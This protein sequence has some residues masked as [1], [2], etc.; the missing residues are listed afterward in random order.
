MK[1]LFVA[2]ACAVALNAQAG[3]IVDNSITGSVVNNFNAMATGAV[4]GLIVDVGARYGERFAG[5]TVTNVGGF[6][7]VTGAPTSLTLLANANTADNIGIL[8]NGGSNVL[9][10]DL[11]SQIGEGAVSVLLGARSDVFGFNMVGTDGG[12]FLIEFF[13]ADGSSI[14]S[15]T[16]GAMNSF[17]GFRTTG[18]SQIWGVTITN[19]D[20]AGLAFDNVQFNQG[21][22]EVPEPASLA[23]LGLGLFGLVAARRRKQ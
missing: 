10:G 1:K 4:A 23:L 22:G 20:P 15:I 12:N 11:S 13:A 19:T 7:A 18:G 2:L 17:F 6:D 3:V 8:L 9:Y 5:Q 16:Q 14:A 21:R